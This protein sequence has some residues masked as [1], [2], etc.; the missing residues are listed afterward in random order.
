MPEQDNLHDK[1]T[2]SNLRCIIFIMC[3]VVRLAAAAQPGLLPHFYPILCLPVAVCSHHKHICKI[4]RFL[5]HFN[6]EIKMFGNTT[7]NKHAHSKFLNY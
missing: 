7:S 6:L 4:S 1:V 3:N 2:E 5:S